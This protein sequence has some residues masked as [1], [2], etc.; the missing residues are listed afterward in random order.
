MARSVGAAGAVGAVGG[1][2]GWLA[3]GPGSGSRG[4]RRA[5]PPGVP[6]SSAGGRPEAW[7]S[8]VLMVKTVLDKQAKQQSTKWSLLS[9]FGERLFF[10]LFF[11]FEE[12]SVF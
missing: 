10:G 7:G 11:V 12:N 2:E 3:G 4:R 9:T 1:G 8:A 6:L 5:L